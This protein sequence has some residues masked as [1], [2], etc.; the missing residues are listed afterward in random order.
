MADYGEID[1]QQD[2]PTSAKLEADWPNVRIELCGS[3]DE[4]LTGIVEELRHSH[5]NGGA[6]LGRFSIEVSPTWRW[7]LSRN[8]FDEAEFFLRFFQHPSVKQTLPELGDSSASRGDLG[9]SME[10]P[11]VLTGR[12][13]GTIANGGAY[14]AFQGTD[15]ELLRLVG[16]FTDAAFEDRY[17]DVLTYV[18]FAPW[19]PW[20]KGVAWD[21]SFFWFDK[22]T[23]VVTS[24]LVTDTD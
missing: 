4:R 7:Y 21:A 8:R 12:L 6:L 20:F 13:A 14:R 1:W 9:F 18:S 5:V 17:S 22:K 2:K 24:L 3:A 23:G 11:H 16:S 15:K 19:S 10:Q